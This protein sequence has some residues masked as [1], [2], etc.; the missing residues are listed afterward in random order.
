ME[1][2]PQPG[3][4]ETRVVPRGSLRLALF[5]PVRGQGG[6][7][8]AGIIGR[9][10][11]RCSVSEVALGDNVQSFIMVINPARLPLPHA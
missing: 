2:V 8:L 10:K 1:P 5:S 11:E 4:G 3:T 7:F 9:C 6:K